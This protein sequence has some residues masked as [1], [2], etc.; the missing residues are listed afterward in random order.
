LQRRIAMKRSAV[1]V[2]MAGLLAVASP[3]RAGDV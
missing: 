1:F 2:L 3:A